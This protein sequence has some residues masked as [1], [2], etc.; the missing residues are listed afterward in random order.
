MSLFVIVSG[1]IGAGKTT[2][3]KA[4]A[5]IFDNSACIEET[6]S[7]HPTLSEYY[8]SID[9]YVADP[10]PTNLK[11]LQQVALITQQ[12]FL[13]DRWHK[14]NQA[15]IVNKNIFADRSIYEDGIFASM[16]T[17]KGW[18]DRESYYKGYL[19]AYTTLTGFLRPP[20]LNIYL[21]C[22]TEWAYQNVLKRS[23]EMEQ[24]A[25]SK[26]YLASLNDN[27]AMWINA[28]PYNTLIVKSSD[29]DKEGYGLAE[30]VKNYFSDLYGFSPLKQS[31]REEILKV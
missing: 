10:N 13:F 19:N 12:I 3:A 30:K 1:I 22:D 2:Q 23:R 25:V 6:V 11:L 24:K 18:M 4:L 28:Y 16:L 29:L 31:I 9:R 17:K 27:Y 21:E 20:D 7:E 15:F 8:A 26:D 14:H 5:K